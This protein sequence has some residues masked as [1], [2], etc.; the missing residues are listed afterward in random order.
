[1]M[2]PQ[3]LLFYNDIHGVAYLYLF[4]TDIMFYFKGLSKKKKPYTY[5]LE[6]TKYEY[7][8]YI[9][10]TQNEKKSEIQRFSNVYM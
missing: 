7:K 5:N 4:Y 1:M 3:S 2:P 6:G 9:E 10:Y 8:I